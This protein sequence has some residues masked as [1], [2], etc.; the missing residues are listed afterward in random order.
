MSNDRGDVVSIV[1]RTATDEQAADALVCLKAWI[2]LME[3]GEI[4]NVAV[5][6][7]GPGRSAFGHSTF[8]DVP[9]LGAVALLQHDLAAKLDQ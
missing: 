8:V 3:T 1:G 4:T 2:K 5:A 9:L 7:V 6:G